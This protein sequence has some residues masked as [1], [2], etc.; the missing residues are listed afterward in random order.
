ML[1]AAVVA[2]GVEMRKGPGGD[3]RAPAFAHQ[4]ESDQGFCRQ[5]EKDFHQ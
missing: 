2:E 5:K 1:R 3:K 4:F